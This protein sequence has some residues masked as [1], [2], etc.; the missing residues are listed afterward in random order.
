MR[1]LFAFSQIN[2]IFNLEAYF[3]SNA[4]GTRRKII[5]CLVCS[6]FPQKWQP[7]RHWRWEG[8]KIVRM[9]SVPNRMVVFHIKSDNWKI[10]AI[11][12]AASHQ[13]LSLCV[14]SVPFISVHFT[15]KSSHTFSNYVCVLEM[16]ANHCCRQWR[17][18]QQRPWLQ[19]WFWNYEVIKY[20]ETT[21]TQIPIQFT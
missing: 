2:V 6:R 14:C 10:V 11:F 17:Q 3:V 7:E 8:K 1:V 4:K 16:Q 13:S 12:R 20:F 19:I 9:A 21:I 15:E 18:Q 5:W